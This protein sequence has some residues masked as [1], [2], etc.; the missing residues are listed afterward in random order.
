MRRRPSVQRFGGVGRPAPNRS[1]A[2]NGIS[3]TRA[4]AGRRELAV[5]REIG[6]NHVLLVVIRERRVEGMDAQFGWLGSKAIRH[7][8][9]VCTVSQ[10]SDFMLV[11]VCWHQLPVAIIS[12]SQTALLPLFP[13]FFLDRFG[14]VVGQ[15]QLFVT[16]DRGEE[17]VLTRVLRRA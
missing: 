9:R 14:K 2:P 5:L 17:F 16:S 15:T 13:Q 4:G 6:Q 8:P 10:S 12:L 3:D 11:V 1:R 7:G